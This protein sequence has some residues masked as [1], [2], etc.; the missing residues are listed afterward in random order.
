MKNQLWNKVK[1]MM[2][3]AMMSALLVTVAQGTF[4]VDDN[5]GISL[6]GEVVEQMQYI[7]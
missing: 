6:Y 2:A 1:R 7:L 3:G 4:G 5:P